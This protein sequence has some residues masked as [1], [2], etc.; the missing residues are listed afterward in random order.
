MPFIFNNDRSRWSEDGF[1]WVSIPM[2]DGAAAPLQ[3]DHQIIESVMA[4][5]VVADLDSGGKSEII[6]ASYDGRLHVYWLDKTEHH[7]W[8]YDVAAA[9]PGVRFA[10]EPIVVDLDNDS[11][12]EVIFTSWPQKGALQVGKLH[13]LDNRGTVLHELPLPPPYGG[14][15]WNGALPAPTIDNIDGDADMEL[16]LNTSHSG[17]VAYDLPGTSGARILWGTGR[18]NYQRTG[19][20]LRGN[21]T[22][23]RF[24]SS[25]NIPAAGETVTYTIEL[26]NSGPDLRSVTL[27]STL[28]A[29]VTYS[30]GLSA[31]SDQASYS[32]GQVIWSGSVT[33]G[34]PTIISYVGAI[35]EDVTSLRA[36]VSI[37][38]IDDSLG[39]TWSLS[40][41]VM[42]NGQALYL[43]SV[44]R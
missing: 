18:A 7:N 16:V 1:S 11:Q 17:I 4:N 14:A 19:S 21:L 24:D 34:L 9:G 33:S 25:P 39:R 5:P 37:V 28:P 32:A 31:T 44:P 2:P 30:A 43:P 3:E 6:Y 23:L 15:D 26:A 29:D 20:Y 41:L 27:T 10:S 40:D 13:I 35:N 36:L 22:N 12:A 38:H 42:A 8:P